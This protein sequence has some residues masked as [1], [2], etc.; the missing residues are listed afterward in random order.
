MQYL[1]RVVAIWARGGVS[2]IPTWKTYKEE[3]KVRRNTV[4]IFA[5]PFNAFTLLR[6]ILKYTRS[7]LTLTQNG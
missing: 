1:N 7:K 3:F 6:F 4:G 2:D 5:Y